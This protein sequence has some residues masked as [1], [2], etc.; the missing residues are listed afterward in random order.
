MVKDDQ[1]IKA[2]TRLKAQTQ[3][4]IAK[5]L[6]FQ[7]S[8]FGSFP[9]I[10]N[11]VTILTARILVLEIGTYVGFSALTWAH[12]IE[13]HEDGKVVTLE[14]DPKLSQVARETFARTGTDRCIELVEGDARKRFDRLSKSR[15][16]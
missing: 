3:V 15:Y 5:A 7:R 8:S 12:A 1:H 2:D 4:W 14:F 11:L 13:G 10:G 6:G 9:S 16:R